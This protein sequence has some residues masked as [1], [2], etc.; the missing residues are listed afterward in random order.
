MKYEELDFQKRKENKNNESSIDMGKGEQSDYEESL[1]KLE[2]EVRSHIRIEQQLKIYADNLQSRNE[3]LEAKIKQSEDEKKSV[4]KLQNEMRD[5][6]KCND[7]LKCQVQSLKRK[8]DLMEKEAKLF[9]SK[10]SY[11]SDN[12]KSQETHKLSPKEEVSKPTHEIFSPTMKCTLLNTSRPQNKV[13][14]SLLENLL[15]K[16]LHSFKSTI[17]RL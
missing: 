2:A 14:D 4:S 11:D 17:R 9:Q 5:K 7:E 1:Q 12:H 15:P 8:I 10:S 6:E 16:F 3:E 13:Y